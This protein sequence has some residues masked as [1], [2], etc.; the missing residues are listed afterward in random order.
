MCPTGPRHQLSEAGKSRMK[1]LPGPDLLE[2]WLRGYAPDAMT[3]V[4][5]FIAR[6][7]ET[8]LTHPRLVPTFF[9]Y[10]L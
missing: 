7:K 5:E 6:D 10:A 3:R 8:W 9:R 2:M 4:N 1:P